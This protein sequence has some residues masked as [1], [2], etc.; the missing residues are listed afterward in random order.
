[1]VEKG[2]LAQPLILWNRTSKKAEDLSKELPSGKTVVATSVS[3]AVDQADLIFTCLSN[4]KAAEDTYTSTLDADVKG[5][6]FVDCSTIH[7]DITNKISQVLQSHGA[8]FVACPGQWPWN[9]FPC[10]GDF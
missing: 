9:V 10:A 3:E 2:N 6:T 4:D 7:P 5:K 8:G 1:M